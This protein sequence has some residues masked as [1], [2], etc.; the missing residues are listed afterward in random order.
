MKRLLMTVC[1]LAASVHAAPLPAQVADAPRVTRLTGGVGKVTAP[2]EVE[3]VPLGEHAPGQRRVRISV[4]PG[5]DAASLAVTV[6][7]ESGLALAA[8][9]QAAWTAP[10]RAGEETARELDLAVTGEGELRLVVE[11]TIAY[12]DVTQTGIRVFAFNPA[13]GADGALTKSFLPVRPTDP[14]GRVI[15]EVPARRP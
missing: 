10:A 11:A 14:G 4:R 2:V 7:A 3:I 13:P 9:A 6:R 15:V 5:V 1:A 8:P 12:G